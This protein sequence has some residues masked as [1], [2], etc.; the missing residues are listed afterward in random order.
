MGWL[1]NTF[2]Q[3]VPFKL[4]RL[5]MLHAAHDRTEATKC[6]DLF[7]EEGGKGAVFPTP[8]KI[9]RLVAGM[10]DVISSQTALWWGMSQVQQLGIN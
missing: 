1:E 5:P 7:N 8:N 4:V 3:T 6:E 2:M 10:V 9:L